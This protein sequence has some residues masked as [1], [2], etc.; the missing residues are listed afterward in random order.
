M[1]TLLGAEKWVRALVTEY[2]YK[3]FLAEI[4][5]SKKFQE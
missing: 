1:E 2:F 3:R 5:G 4:G